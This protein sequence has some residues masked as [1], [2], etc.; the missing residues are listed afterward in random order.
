M[1]ETRPEI[2]NSHGATCAIYRDAPV[3]DNKRTAAIGNFSCDSAGAGSELLQ[4]AVRTLS[5]QGFN[6]VIGPMDGDTWHKYR[7]ISES[8]NSAPYFLEPVSGAFDYAAF[9]GAGFKPISSY[10]SARAKA[11]DAI[12]PPAPAIPGVTISAWD[13][14]NADALTGGM[15]DLSRTAF[16]G[17]A[18][19]KPI[20]REDFL[21]LYQPILPAID[22]R[23][24]LFARAGGTL[25]GYLFAIPDRL[26]GPKPSTAIIKTYASGV[27]GAGHMLLDVAHRTIRDLGYSDVIHALM[28]VDNP[29]RE[30]SAR[31]RGTVFRRYDLMGL[32]LEKRR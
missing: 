27:R 5:T 32:N 21:K 15:F 22:P 24:V 13:G 4:S 17:N 3:W 28:H 12:G 8:D 30:R 10:V 14:K 9:N 20:E 6:A 7:V 19:Y 25:V 26:Q 18:F 16:T 23:L 31:H 29:S 11:E 1:S 2:M